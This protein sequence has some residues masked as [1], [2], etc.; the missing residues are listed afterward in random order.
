MMWIEMVAWLAAALPVA[1]LAIYSLELVAGMAAGR[2]RAAP[3]GTIG[4]VAILVPAH[5][6][7]AGIAATVAG[8]R[9]VAPAGTRILV[10]ADNCADDTAALARAA[11]ARVV[12]RSDARLRGKGYALAFGRDVLAA[13]PPATVLVVDADC[14][15]APG[16][17]EHL[18]AATA[19]GAPAQA[20]NLLIPDR[21][22]PALVQISSFALLVKNLIRSRGL[23]RIGGCALLTGTGMAFPWPVFAAAPL[24]SGD[25]AE[26][27]GLCI[28]LARRGIRARLVAEASVRSRAAS[29]RDS[30]AQRR[31]WEH[32]FLANAQ[33]HALP[34]LG[35]GIATRSRA[36]LALGLH[37][38]VPPLALL[39]LVAGAV[40]AL[41]VGVGA[42]WSIW[43]PAVAL[44]L[45]M[46]LALTLTAVGWFRHGR[47]T[48]T[49]AALLQAP[50]YVAWKIPNYVR[51]LF[52]R[53]TRWQRAGRDGDAATLSE[54]TRPAD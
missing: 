23:S 3:A 30:A 9:E 47:A 37:L 48:L 10:V 43:P 1:A 51:F 53:E 54:G 2:R 26:D 22:A 49:F 12:E 28:A 31:R 15:L 7:A 52:R 45:A 19:N 40:L 38:L 20:I 39:F 13:D 50:V 16:S 11:G 27:L 6:E 4:S 14:A 34:T 25:I 35:A 33:R 5:D 21:K 17:V 42:V 41:L 32:G 8:L 29:L 18:C 44:G 24:A 46:A 36:L